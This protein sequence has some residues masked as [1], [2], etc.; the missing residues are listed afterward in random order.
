MLLWQSDETREHRPTVLDEVRNGLYFVEQTLFELVPQIYSE[1][2]RALAEIYPD[3][4]FDIPNFLA[5][6]LLGWR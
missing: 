2:E 4:S 1:L 5:L 3:E 6:R